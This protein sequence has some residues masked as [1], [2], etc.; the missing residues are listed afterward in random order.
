MG[1]CKLDNNESYLAHFDE[2]ENESFASFWTLGLDP[3]INLQNLVELYTEQ[4]YEHLSSSFITILLR[5]AQ[6]CL[7]GY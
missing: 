1:F 3:M 2:E 7:V 5:D 4:V 6:H